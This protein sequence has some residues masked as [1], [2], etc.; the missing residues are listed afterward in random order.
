MNDAM[1]ENLYSILQKGFP[2]D[3][4]AAC[5]ILPGGREVNYGMLQQ[6]SARFANLIVSLGVQ[7][8][9]R[10]AVQVE[11]TAAAVLLY[12]GCLRAG[13]VFLPMNV[14][15]QRHELEYFLCDAT[16]RLFV[17]R[18]QVR[19][20]AD[21]LAAK[22]GVNTVLE[23]NDDGGG[24]LIKAAA[25]HQNTFV[26]VPR[27]SADLAAILYTSGTTGRPK[28]AMLSHGNLTANARVLH[29]HW[30]FCHG[31]VLLHMLPIFH[32]HG[33]F[34]AIHCALLNGSPMLF[35]PRFDAAR[36]VA[37]LSR[38]TVFMGV[39]TYYVRL[40][41]EAGLT[42]DHCAGMR[43][44][45]SGSAPLLKETFDDFRVRT[46][47]T[48]LE[49]Y[50]MTEGGMFTSNPYN[51]ERRGGTVGFP[52]PGTTI[53]IVDD[54]GTPVKS[55][56]VGNIL[57]KGAQVFV[58]YW[59]MPEKTREEFT[60]EIFFKTGDLGR[61]DDDGYI[62]I[63]G[64][65]R[66][67]I[68]TGGLNVYPKEIEE[69]VDAMSGVVESAVIGRPDPDLGEVVTA[70]V[71]RQKNAAGDAVTEAGIISALK[72]TIA[73]FK[74]PKQVFFVDDLPRNTMGKVQKNVLQQN[75]L[76]GDWTTM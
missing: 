17:C 41:A 21:E 47:H 40:L 44:F 27:R 30:G 54:A 68:I 11:K 69:M 15:Y 32:A 4:D 74:I 7:P 6:E 20:L 8:G 9:D 29:R 38:A 75:V 10:V 3:P 56:E 19:L 71:V 43:L 53:R 14:A 22:A 13:A 28:G 12:L 46:G 51:A 24:S 37:L 35:E 65:S 61:L 16:P 49:R 34:V 25:E 45:I 70:V 67:L 63:I 48:I 2:A 18:P 55:G 60:E 33:L 5:L 31:D 39:P 66:D 62:T 52:L 42:R 64:R 50:G 57:V 73:G 23:L 1:N 76:S 26:T 59:Q 36:A 58:G 72:G